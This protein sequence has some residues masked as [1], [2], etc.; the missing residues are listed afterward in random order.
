MCFAAQG[1]YLSRNLHRVVNE[2]ISKAM[3]AFAATGID[4]DRYTVHI[5][6]NANISIDFF[7]PAKVCI[8]DTISVC[9]VIFRVIN[10]SVL[11]TDIKVYYSNIL[12]MILKVYTAGMRV[13][14]GDIFRPSTTE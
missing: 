13:E 10:L 14:G 7:L 8:I 5:I 6:P 12:S 3:A 2:I 1:R 11:N 4:P 9:M